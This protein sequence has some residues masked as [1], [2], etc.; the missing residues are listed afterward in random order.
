MPAAPRLAGSDGA[1]PH[2][3]D[4]TRGS[5]R[6]LRAPGLTQLTAPCLLPSGRVGVC[7]LC[8]PGRLH[9]AEPWLSKRRK[10]ASWPSRP[11]EPATPHPYPTLTPPHA[12]QVTTEEDLE[13][14]FS[15]FGNITSCDIIRRVLRHL[16]AGQQ[17]GGR[18]SGRGDPSSAC[19][20]SWQADDGGM[21]G[22]ARL[23]AGLA[24]AAARRAVHVAKRR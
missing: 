19:A 3:S 6:R 20:A 16:S 8:Q 24:L 12:W 2:C 10:G 7:A 22:R 18:L 4:P 1:L 13:I 23:P 17:W 5:G 9:P 14:I 21:G 11:C 15:R